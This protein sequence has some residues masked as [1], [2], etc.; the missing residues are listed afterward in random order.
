[1]KVTLLSLL[2]L[3]TTLIVAIVAITATIDPNDYKTDIESAVAQNSNLTLTID[4]DLGWSFMPLGIDI[5]GVTLNHLDGKTFTSL[6]QLTAQVGLISLLKLNPQVHKVI[7]DGL[8]VTL[9]KNEQGE[10]NWENITAKK[11]TGST[12]SPEA[13]VTSAASAQDNPSTPSR[14]KAQQANSDFQ[15]EIEEVAIINTTI[16]YLDKQS[17]QSASLEDLNLLAN[18][19]SLGGEFPLS[20]EFKVSNSQPK[21]D[22]TATI[23]AAITI[24]NNMR[25]VAV[26]QLNSHYDIS[27]TP[28]SGNNLS[29]SFN[30]K[31][32]IADLDKDQ[33]T[34]DEIALQLANLTLKT[35]LEIQN[36][37]KQ[38]KLDGNLA[39]PAFSL[40][41]L[42]ASLGLPAIDTS[43]KNVLTQIGFKTLLEGTAED[44]KLNNIAIRLDDTSYTGS[45]NYRAVNQYIAANIKGSELNV[46]RYLPPAKDPVTQATQTIEHETNKDENATNTGQSAPTPASSQPEPQLLPLETIRSL[47]LDISFIQQTL[48]AKNL[49]LNDLTLLVKAADGI[50]TVS[51]ASGKLYEGYFDVN[52]KIDASTDNPKWTIKKA[53]NN[54]QVLPLLKDLQDLEII[55]GGVNLN[56]DI[57]STGNTVSA[58]RNS[59][60]GNASFDFD[61]GAFHGFNLTKLT[62]EGVALINRDRVTKSDW[63][64][65]SEFQ[66]M[67]G[68]LTVNGNKFTNNNLTAAMSGLALIGKGVIDTKILN[69]NY[70]IDLKAIGNLG[71]N[72]CRVNEKVKDLAIPIVCNGPLNGDPAKLCKLDYNR[73]QELVAAAGKKELE[74]KADKEVDKLLDKHLGGDNAETKKSVKKLLKGLF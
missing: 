13:K 45:L 42:L 18:N 69:I 63:S 2:G 24:D 29:A 68:V 50:V 3:L 38:P 71:D 36:L 52:A 58:L 31:Q 30:G 34:L 6:N 37:S 65:K 40:Q 55:S 15:F 26:R 28:L 54:I 53:V 27:G 12:Q 32:I 33:V 57:K 17:N 59:A 23:D 1:M 35:N 10:A 48:I 49:T 7:V 73:M 70:G 60:K 21:L 9:E 62:C 64:N 44:L 14:D 11:V 56:A 47:N 43:D 39:I 4:G 22:I 46:D 66:S 51:E 20:I 8:V 61:K 16:R 72:A 74:R 25:H 67:S 41:T 19:I 5:S